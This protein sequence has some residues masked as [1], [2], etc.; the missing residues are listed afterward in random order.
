MP[1]NKQKQKRD[2]QEKVIPLT[3]FVSADTHI[4]VIGIVWSVQNAKKPRLKRVYLP[5]E[6]NDLRERIA[7]DFPYAKKNKNV[8][9]PGVIGQLRS[10]LEGDDIFISSTI[11]DLTSCT[12]FERRIYTHVRAIPR[13]QVRTYR[14]MAA[15][16]GHGR[17]ARAVGNALK[18]NPFPLIIP[19]HR[20]IP[21]SRCVGAFQA[22]TAIKW[23]LLE[24]EGVK[25]KN[26]GRIQ[27]RCL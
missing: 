16:V 3:F 4:G 26:D 17:A 1:K 6:S 15:D 22:G 24:K 8:P 12:P 23:A 11:L 13:G 18:K 5:I 27:D 10:C 7:I 25:I 21:S 2:H 19:C 14:Y 9:F 20:V